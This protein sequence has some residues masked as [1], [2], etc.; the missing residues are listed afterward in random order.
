VES[1]CAQ[2][3]SGVVV[4]V[5]VATDHD[6]A[7]RQFGG[8]WVRADHVLVGSGWSYDGERFTPPDPPPYPEA[9]VNINVV[10]A[11]P[12]SVRLL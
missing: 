1:Y 11:G 12:N 8:Q 5:I 9:T 3:E 7:S 6:W 4:R 10:P 2:I